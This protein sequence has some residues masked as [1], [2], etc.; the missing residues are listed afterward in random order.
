MN[1]GTWA[2]VPVKPFADAKR[3]LAPLLDAAERH[4]LARAM[5]L[6]VLG[7]LLGARALAGILVVTGDAEAA[8]IA[9]RAG[10]RVL[11]EP[12]NRGTSAAADEAALHLAGRRCTTM[13]VLPADLPLLRSADVEAIVLAHRGARAV[14]L[15][16]ATADGGTNALCCSP[17]GIIAARFGETSFRHHCDATR[18][19]GID[20]RVVANDRVGRD[21]DRPDDLIDFATSRTSTHTYRYLFEAAI[22]ERLD[23]SRREREAS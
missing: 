15:V 11:A 3:R 22:L 19:A 13:L 4:A 21:I 23:G 2:V 18:A 16:R 9:Q 5:F 8:A 20:P 17:P 1:P 10:A 6:D 7:A 14:T 12:R